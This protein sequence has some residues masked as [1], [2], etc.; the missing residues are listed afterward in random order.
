MGVS[1]PI[2]AGMNNSLGWA[3]TGY[4]VMT[5]I[6]M[7]YI[8]MALAGP[9]PRLPDDRLICPRPPF[10]GGAPPV[11]VQPPTLGIRLPLCSQELLFTKKRSAVGLWPSSSSVAWMRPENGSLFTMHLGACRR[12][13]P[14]GDR[15]DLKV[16]KG[17]SHRDILDAT[18]ASEAGI[19]H[20][21]PW[22]RKP[23]QRSAL[24]SLACPPLTAI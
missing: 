17:A 16:P 14:G 21:A 13:M 5:Y 24:G 18:L 22:H 20:S 6:V 1:H 23:K 11:R 7:V 3:D 8:V 2:A 12:R 9:M 10:S 19:R 15:A 4:I